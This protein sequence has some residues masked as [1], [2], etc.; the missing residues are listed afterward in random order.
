VTL[1]I[2]IDFD[3]TIVSYDELIYR[4]ARDRGLIRDGAEPTKRS[5]R[6]RIRQ[7]PGGEIE[8]Q[9]LQALVYGPLMRDAR[10]TDGAEDFIRWCRCEADLAVFIVSHKTEYARY[11]QTGTNLR[12]AAFDWMAAHR[13]FEPGGLGLSR[14]AVHFESTR[15]EKIERIRAIGCSYFVD[16]LEEVFLEPSFPSHVQKILYAPRTPRASAGG[17]IV[18]AG[19]QALREY[20]VHR[21]A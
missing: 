7:L 3:N 1:T 17:A 20:F 15:V 18:M 12:T 10:P 16:D 14:S 21:G 9:K 2:G 8:W 5:V 6:D 4:T 19:W 13:F 11:D